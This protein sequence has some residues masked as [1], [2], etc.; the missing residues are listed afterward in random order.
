[1]V[2]FEEEEEEKHSSREQA[3]QPHQGPALVDIWETKGE[4]TGQL[5]RPYTFTPLHGGDMK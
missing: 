5:E 4:E 1:M 3:G 2:L